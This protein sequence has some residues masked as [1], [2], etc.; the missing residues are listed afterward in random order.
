MPVDKR[1]EIP[2]PRIR[3]V[4]A[5]RGREGFKNA[6]DAQKAPSLYGVFNLIYKGKLL[7]D[8]NISITRFKNIVKKEI[9]GSKVRL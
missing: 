3:I 1:Q 8:R 4:A 7:A 9:I 2:A 5:G 6:E